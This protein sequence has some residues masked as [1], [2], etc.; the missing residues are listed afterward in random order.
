MKEISQFKATRV[1]R[2]LCLATT[3][4]IVVQKK[5]LKSKLLSQEAERQTSL[6]SFKQLRT[7]P[8]FLRLPV[9][10]LI[11]TYLQQSEAAP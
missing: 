6:E 2:K 8:L 9:S 7:R 5:L 4:E 3:Y 11:P 10:K 1:N